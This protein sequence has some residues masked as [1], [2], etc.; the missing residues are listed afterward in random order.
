MG[1]DMIR[2]TELFA[3]IDTAQIQTQN[4][5]NVLDFDFI[6]SQGT[7]KRDDICHYRFNP[8]KTLYDVSTVDGY[9]MAFHTAAQLMGVDI[10]Q[11]RLDFCFDSY[12]NSYDKLYK[13]NRLLLLLVAYKY[14]FTNLMNTDNPFELQKKSIRVQNTKDSDWIYQF[15]FYNKRIQ[16]PKSGIECRLELRR[17]KLELSDVIE[18]DKPKHYLQELM[19][20]LKS[21]VSKR[22]TTFTEFV[23]AQ[24]KYLL[25]KWQQEV[26]TERA[27]KQ[28]LSKFMAKYADCFY[29]S[30]QITE[31]IKAL[32]YKDYNKRSQDIREK[33][34]FQL[35]S[36]REMND[37]V[38]EITRSATAFLS[39]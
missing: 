3:Q 36:K 2:T 14:K 13:Q 8:Q 39:A 29:T 4:E 31:F 28:P 6:T 20:M 24:N 32:G 16:S 38:T 23:R 26:I 25:A 18:D 12:D 5:I 19:D 37:Y 11:N 30:L 17:R 27:Y 22:D 15:E 35:F 7:Y 1:V 9:N 10:L 33:I 21:V 34:M